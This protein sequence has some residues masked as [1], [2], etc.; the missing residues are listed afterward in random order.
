MGTQPCRPVFLAEDGRRMALHSEAQHELI[1]GS[2]RKL[3][4]DPGDAEI[5]A[6]GSEHHVSAA[7]TAIRRFVEERRQ[8]G[9][10]V[11]LQ[12]ASIMPGRWC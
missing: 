12:G 2:L 5:D 3:D 1:V 11:P 9:A 10:L 6:E 8:R 7:T 4:A